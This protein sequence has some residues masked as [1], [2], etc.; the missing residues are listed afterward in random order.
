MPRLSEPGPLG[1][2]AE[3]WYDVGSLA[4]NSNLSVQVVAHMAA[5]AGPT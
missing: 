3:R 5:A 2:R 1:M 4:G